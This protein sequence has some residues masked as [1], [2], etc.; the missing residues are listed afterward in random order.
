MNAALILS[1]GLALR[2]GRSNTTLAGWGRASSPAPEGPSPVSLGR[3]TGDERRRL[4]PP[5]RTADVLP[6]DTVIHASQTSPFDRSQTGRNPCCVVRRDMACA[7]R[8]RT[9]ECPRT[10]A[11]RTFRSASPFCD[12]VG[13][14]APGKANDVSRQE[15]RHD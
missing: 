9:P 1:S 6:F 14:G 8:L 11:D 2:G 7:L 3:H 15:A 4:V 5:L 13:A 12:T 10:D